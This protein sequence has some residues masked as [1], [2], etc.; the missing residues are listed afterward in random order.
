MLLGVIADDFTG[1]G[2]IANTLAKG[3]PREGGMRTAQ[4]TGTP[5][6]AAPS[7]IEAGVIALKI[8]SAAVQDAIDASVD[9]LHWL[10]AQGCQQIVFKYCSTFDSTEAGNIGPVAEALAHELDTS[11]VVICPAFPAAG[12]TLYQGHLFVKDRLLSESGMEHHPLTPMTDPDVR[13]WLRHQTASEIGHISHSTVAEGTEAVGVALAAQRHAHTLIVVDAVSEGDLIAIGKACAGVKLITGGSGIAMA[14]P[15]NFRHAGHLAQKD[16]GRNGVAGPAAI[17]AG[18][19]S[20]ATRQQV[21]AYAR[22]NPSYAIDV[23]AVMEGSVSADTVLEF[24]AAQGT[25]TALVY[26]SDKPDEVRRMQG[27]IGRDTIAET[28]E[29]L[30]ATVAVTLIERGYKRLI[31]AGGETSG[32]VTSALNPPLLRVGP[33]IAPGVPV[34]FSE[35][36]EPYALA[37]KS[38]NFG[39]PAFF[40]EALRLMEQSR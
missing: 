11:G 39:G 23:R 33:E 17:L 40:K 3:L 18:S 37:L 27:R 1:A 36:S 7:D 31:V 38:G 6:A 26:S 8:R 35:G 34:L 28:L 13:R 19:C 15:D 12:R 29:T 24:I 5:R 2:D 16:S 10:L 32:A 20:A 25:N 21:K 22:H 4:F 30:F 14:L 9:A